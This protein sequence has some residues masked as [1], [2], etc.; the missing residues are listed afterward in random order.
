V[1]FLGEDGVE[2]CEHILHE[3]GLPVEADDH[4]EEGLDEGVGVLLQ[5]F[6]LSCLVG[7]VEALEVVDGVGL[8]CGLLASGVELVK[9][10][11]GSA[12]DG[13]EFLVLLVEAE[14]VVGEL[15]V[16]LLAHLKIR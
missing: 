11:V 15:L 10:E 13:L 8:E 7:L 6:F 3:V 5:Q 4:I 9:P 14:R 1:P 16:L 12:C 2:G